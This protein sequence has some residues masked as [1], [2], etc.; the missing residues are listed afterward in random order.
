VVQGSHENTVFS[1]GFGVFQGHRW[2]WEHAKTMEGGAF[3]HFG[4]AF[5]QSVI[6]ICILASKIES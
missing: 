2:I 4:A 5:D 3:S 1:N 6:N